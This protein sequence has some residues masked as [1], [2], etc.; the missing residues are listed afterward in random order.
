MAAAGVEILIIQDSILSKAE[1]KVV[2]NL[3][4]AAKEAELK[5]N[6]KNKKIKIEYKIFC[7]FKISS[8]FF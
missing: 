1:F 4:Y 6:I 3:G 7:F 8:P 2:I 5:K